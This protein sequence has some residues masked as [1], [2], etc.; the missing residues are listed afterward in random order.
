MHLSRLMVCALMASISLYTSHAAAA[1]NPPFIYLLVR[2][3][4]AGCVSFDKLNL[5]TL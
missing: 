3:L 2:K 4:A 1:G 5:F